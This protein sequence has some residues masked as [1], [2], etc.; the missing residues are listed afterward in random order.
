[1]PLSLPNLDDRTYNDLVAEALNLIP[2]Y[3]PEWTNHNP[4]DPGIT[5]I[6][7]FAH[8][9]EMLLYR[10]NRITQQNIQMFLRLLNNPEWQPGE[11]LQRDVQDT[12]LNLRQHDRVVTCED[13][14]EIALASDPNVARAYCVPRRNLES[15][16][17]L[18]RSVNRPGHISVIVIPQ[19]QDPIPQ[20]TP[21]LLQL[22]K[23]NLEPRR[24][25]TTRVHVVGPRYFPVGIRL[26]L[27]L[28]RDAIESKT[29]D[30]AISALKKFFDPLMGGSQGKGWSFGRNVY[31]S[32]IYQ[33]LDNLSGVDYVTR[34]NDRDELIVVD[35]SRLV[36]QSEELVAVEIRPEELVEFRLDTSEITIKSPLQL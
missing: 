10:Q 5:L 6:E 34:T 20:P 2:T 26:T 27:V 25:L 18:D 21:E 16:N 11:D 13:F 15:E 32:E 33:L 22:I 24:L 3:A 36:Q 29:H 8:I 4:S 14:E 35:R 7:M 9:T 17:S 28:K 31:V 30:A 1:M 23:D 19:S 12:V